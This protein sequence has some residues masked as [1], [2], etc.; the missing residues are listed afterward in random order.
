[1]SW[2]EQ[3]RRAQSGDTE[4]FAAVFEGLRPMV[5]AI[6]VR[7]LGPA[8]GEDAV[9]EIF[10]KAWKALPGFSARSSLKTW[11]YRIAM[12][13]CN[14]HLRYR[15]RHPEEPLPEDGEGRLRDIPAPPQDTPLDQLMDRDRQAL[16]DRCLARLPEIHRVVLLLRYAD[17]L[18]YGEIAAA[19]GVS[20]GTVMSRLFHA[21]RK[22]LAMLKEEGE[23]GSGGMEVLT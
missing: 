3:L 10:L 2:N 22:L 11:L 14:D 4:A 20:A 1:M 13:H 12:N 21:R 17:G 23:A 8:D 15:V 9:M 6:A 5:T 18:G 19:T 16:L 7:M